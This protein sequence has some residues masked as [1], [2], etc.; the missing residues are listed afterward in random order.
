MLAAI[1]GN[2][3]LS[4]TD[5]FGVLRIIGLKLGRFICFVP[6]AAKGVHLLNSV[7][8]FLLDSYPLK[9]LRHKKTD[10]QELPLFT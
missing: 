10:C 4:H 3:L 2:A 9:T 6:L 5:G 8:F 7:Q 1:Q